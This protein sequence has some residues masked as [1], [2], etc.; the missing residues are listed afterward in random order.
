[1]KIGIIASPW[2][3][4]PPPAYGGTETVIHNLC[5]GLEELGH[6]VHLVTVGESTCPVMRSCVFDE[7]PTAI[8]EPIAEIVQARAAYQLLDGADIIHDHTTIGPQFL[9]DDVPAHVPVVTT[10]H[11]PFAA[12]T[13]LMY[14]GRPERLHVITISHA[15]RAAAPEIEVDAVIHH[16]VDLDL[17]RPGPGGGGYLMFIGRMSPDKGPD[18]AIEV[19]RRAGMPIILSAKM[20]E[21]CETSYFERCVRP[22]LGDDATFLGEAD[23]AE[24][25]RLLRHAEALV[26]PI[27]WPEPFGLVMAEALACGTPVI[28][29]GHGAA[30]E[31]VEHERTGFLC[32]DLDQ[33]VAAVG[34]LDRI[35]RWEVRNAAE[36]RFSVRRMAADH[37][38]LYERL[39]AQARAMATRDLVL[40][41]DE[42]LDADQPT[43]IP[44]ASAASALS[45]AGASATAVAPVTATPAARGAGSPVVP[46]VTSFDPARKHGRSR[47]LIR[48]RNPFAG[49]GTIT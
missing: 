38:A 11:G 16:G 21:G 23:T 3:P 40:D 33:M 37:V 13:R 14:A 25:V 31:I 45:A 15:Q 9:P 44:A 8:G 42:V 19:A 47:G 48:R 5:I 35:D 6:E 4:I 49:P 17:Y 2:I 41:V 36:Q 12:E 28:A 7:P 18:R 20:R 30:P 10:L 22:L 27:R 32:E 39:V 46:V 26:N 29:L 1:M 34:R 43:G 24:R